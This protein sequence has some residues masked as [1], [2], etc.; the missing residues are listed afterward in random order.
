MNILGRPGSP[1][2]QLYRTL[3]LKARDNDEVR[4]AFAAEVRGLCET[5]GLEVPEWKPVWEKLPEEARISG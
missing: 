4:Q 2:N 1:R 3:R 5:S